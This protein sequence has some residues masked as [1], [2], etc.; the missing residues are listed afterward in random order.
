MFKARCHLSISVLAFAHLLRHRLLQG[1]EV[2][3]DVFANDCHTLLTRITFFFKVALEQF[4]L[5]PDRVRDTFDDL[6]T[7]MTH[8]GKAFSEHLLA[9]GN[10]SFPLVQLL[11][12]VSPFSVQEV[13]D[14]GQ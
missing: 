9:L 2:L 14:V 13:D 11:R 12:F 7:G 10:L 6:I 4:L 5:L 1:W 8:I 3:R